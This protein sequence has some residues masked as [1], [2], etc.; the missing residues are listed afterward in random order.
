MHTH[1]H[2]HTHARARTHKHTTTS[3]HPRQKPALSGTVRVAVGGA[4]VVRRWADIARF[5]YT[6]EAALEALLGSVAVQRKEDIQVAK[7][8]EANV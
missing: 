7:E 5:G 3:T 6:P 8:G 4:S 1:T 2:T